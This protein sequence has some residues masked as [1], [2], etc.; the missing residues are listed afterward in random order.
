MAV[1]IDKLKRRASGLQKIGAQRRRNHAG[2]WSGPVAVV[3]SLSKIMRHSVTTSAQLLPA[4]S[5]RGGAQ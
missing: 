3:R 4:V 1:A 2:S 5:F